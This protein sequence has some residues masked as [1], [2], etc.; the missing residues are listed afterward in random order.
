MTIS[1]IPYHSLSEISKAFPAAKYNTMFQ[2]I[3]RGLSNEKIIPKKV[4]TMILASQNN[5]DAILS[6]P[7]IDYAD[8]ILK[9]MSLLSE[10]EFL[11]LVLDKKITFIASKLCKKLNINYVTYNK[12]KK[13]F[14]GTGAW[15]IYEALE[16]KKRPDKRMRT[17]NENIEH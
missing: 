5:I 6:E 17:K 7:Y 13:G 16:L 8:K 14:Y 2:N 10:E 15:S 4:R 12:R 9:I 3:N 11:Q 1:G